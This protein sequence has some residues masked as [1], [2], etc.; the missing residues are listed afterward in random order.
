MAVGDLRST[1]ALPDRAPASVPTDGKS[2]RRYLIAVLIGIGVTVIPYLWVLCDLWTR[3]PSLL[4]TAQSN[5]YAGNFYDLQA[6]AMFHGHFFVANGALGE[7]AFVHD[8]HQYTYFGIF[9]SLLRMPLLLVT[10]SLDGRLSAPSILLAWS[11][12][13]IFVSLLVWRIRIVIRGPLVL[14]RTE[15]AAYGVVVANVM[16]GSV[17]IA[18]ASS[19]S[20]F[21][22]DVAWSVA[23]TIGSVFTLLG[24][25]ERP[26]WGRVAASGALILA[27][28]L[29]RGSTG[30]ASALGAFLVAVCFAVDRKRVSNRRWVFPMLLVALIPLAASCLVDYAKFGILFGLAASD[31]LI[32]TANHLKGSYFGFHFLPSTLLAY[33]GPAGLRLTSVFPFITYPTR[34]HGVG[35]I[36]LWGSDWIASVPTAMPLLF[37]LALWGTIATVRPNGGKSSISIRIVLATAAAAGATVMVFGW[38]ANRF[39]GDLVP[40]LVVGSAIGMVDL[41]RRLSPISRRWRRWTLVAITALGLFG[42]AANIAFAVSY[43]TVWSSQQA[44]NFATFQNSI[45]VA[46]G[47]PLRSAV[48]QGNALALQAPKGQLFIA[49]DCNGLYMSNGLAYGSKLPKNPTP[50]QKIVFQSLGWVPVDAVH[51][52]AALSTS[53]FVRRFQVRWVQ[54][55]WRPSVVIVPPF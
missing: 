16:G 40:V 49:G 14:G 34:A 2:R 50:L 26:S 17:L 36:T 25:L 48:M 10:S 33:F 20:V 41:W 51:R 9:P 3:S 28:N 35:G 37:I 13:A 55:P 38:V 53:P 22:E 54:F 52:S 7:E 43:Q 18:L 4:R 11:V 45:S 42:V 44:L 5:G 46:T 32:Y 6:R 21:T 30:Y 31:Q 24:V 19:P 47:D 1:E 15:A 27:A 29:T 8:G 39:V 12:T 23:L